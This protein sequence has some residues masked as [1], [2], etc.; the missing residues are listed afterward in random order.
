MSK[1]MVVEISE[2]LKKL[3][4]TWKKDAADLGLRLINGN[5]LGHGHTLVKVD[6]WQDEIKKFHQ[7]NE[8]FAVL[9]IA[10]LDNEEGG[11]IEEV[12]IFIKIDS[13]NL[14]LFSSAV[15]PFADMDMEIDDED[16][17]LYGYHKIT[18][19][20]QSLINSTA[21]LIAKENVFGSFRNRDQREN[22]IASF[23]KKN[24]IQ[25]LPRDCEYH[26]ACQAEVI[27]EFGLLPSRA[28]ELRNQ[29]MSTNEIAKELNIT[30]DKAKK[31]VARD[32]PDNILELMS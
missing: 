28:K 10:Y 2:S 4:N 29:G 14:W 9:H 16:E 17:D 22:F 7:G 21:L 30:K 25:N 19:E 3:A 12:S 26:I 23:V 5:L 31:V 1:E 32:I 24:N 6:K 11:A 18:E 15:N 13:G 20:E 8:S 27:Y